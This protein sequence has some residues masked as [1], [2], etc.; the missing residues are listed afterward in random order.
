MDGECFHTHCDHSYSLLRKLL[1]QNKK[2]A[3]KLL[4]NMWVTSLAMQYLSVGTNACIFDHA[5][6]QTWTVFGCVISVISYMHHYLLTI[7]VHL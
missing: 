7:T 5:S 2:D 3:Y 1:S 4:Y 6:L